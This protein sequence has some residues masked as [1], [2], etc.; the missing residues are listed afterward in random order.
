MGDAGDVEGTSDMVS[1][2]T[3]FMCVVK[4]FLIQPICKSAHTLSTPFDRNLL[5]VGSFGHGQREKSGTV[6]L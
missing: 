5:A 1:S 3:P 6:V 4:Q 2:V